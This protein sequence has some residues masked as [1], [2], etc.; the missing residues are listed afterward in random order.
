MPRMSKRKAMSVPDS[1]SG[2]HKKRRAPT[3]RTNPS[4][5]SRL[6]ALPE[7]LLLEILDLFLDPLY[8]ET[9]VKALYSLCLTNRQFYRLAKNYLYNVV[10][11]RLGDGRKLLRTL[12]EEPHMGAKIRNLAFLDEHYDALPK[13]ENNRHMLT[14]IERR[15]LCKKVQELGITNP[16]HYSRVFQGPQP[17]DHLAALLLLTPNVQCL[18]ICDQN[19]CCHPRGYPVDPAWMR[20]LAEVG[21][22][23]SL[24]LANHFRNLHTIRISMGPIKFN[25]IAPVL[26]IL[27]LRTLMLEDVYQGG[28]TMQWLWELGISPR[29]SLLENLYLESSY[30][31]SRAV[32]QLLH[33]I[34]SLRLFV[35]EFDNT[36]RSGLYRIYENSPPKLSYPLL[37]AAI[38]EQKDS[39]EQ[40][41]IENSADPD[42]EEIFSVEYGTLGSLHE[43][44]KLR[45][46]DVGLD[47]YTS[48]EVSF[49]DFDEAEERLQRV[50]LAD[51]LPA[52]ISQLDLNI[53]EEEDDDYE[54]YWG[55]CLEDLANACETRLS[56]LKEVKVSRKRFG[57][58]CT[59][60]GI[61]DIKEIFR[62]NGVHLVFEQRDPAPPSTWAT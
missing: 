34:H 51:K 32:A 8:D 10:D 50:N 38:L 23:E 47:C 1:S 30:V 28:E 58:I 29:S 31:D 2:P 55:D 56:A 36:V 44:H 27:S 60:S 48:T 33:S 42:L 7:E 24:P 46:L 21:F 40:L 49:N 3:K 16:R 53:E 11:N 13:E 35:F 39:L 12:I 37:T 45:F 59:A 15:E 25:S 54:E 22:H 61:H 19:M 57:P 4:T 6:C 5:A 26:G 14:H 52:N 18:D 43:M 62:D 17:K 20:I 9:D 41:S